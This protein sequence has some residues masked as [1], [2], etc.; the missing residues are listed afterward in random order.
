VERSLVARKTRGC[1]HLAPTASDGCNLTEFGQAGLSRFAMTRVHFRR[2]WTACASAIIAVSALSS[3][4]NT[5]A[6]AQCQFEWLIR[7]GPDFGFAINAPNLYDQIDV[8]RPFWIAFGALSAD[9]GADFDVSLYK[10]DPAWNPCPEPQCFCTLYANSILGSGRTDFVVGDFNHNALT[11][12]WVWTHCFGGSCTVTPAGQVAWRSGDLIS[13]NA[14]PRTVDITAGSGDGSQVLSIFDVYLSAGTTYYFSFHTTGDRQSKLLLFANVAAGTYWAGRASAQFETDQCMTSYAAPVTGY[15]GVVVVNDRLT[16]NPASFRLAVTTSV[17]CDCPTVLADDVSQVLPPSPG[18]ARDIVIQG[19]PMW[20][21]V[22]ARSSADWDL[23]VGNTPSS[24]PDLG[25]PSD[26]LA[27]SNL[28]APK[29]DVLA[30]D[31][32]WKGMDPPSHDTVSVR[33]SLFSGSAPATVQMDGTTGA[34]D[35]IPDNGA[36]QSGTLYAD[37]VLRVW[38]VLLSQDTTYTFSLQTCCA[39]QRLL[40][41]GNSNH[42]VQWVGRP[43]AILE[44]SSTATFKPLFTGYYG[45]VVLKEDGNVGGFSLGFGHCGSTTPLVTRTPFLWNRAV[46]STFDQPAGQWA[47]VGVLGNQTDWDIRQ[48][49]QASGSSWPDCFGSPGALSAGSSSMDFIVGDFHHNPPGPQYARSYQFTSGAD[50]FS[51]TEWDSGSGELVVNDTALT[52]TMDETNV[53]HLWCYQVHLVSGLPY[54]F[55]FSRVGAADTHL[56]LFMNPT[57]GGYWAPRSAAVFSTTTSQP[58]IAPQTGWYG[59]V[60]TLDNWDTGRFSLRVSSP[61]LDVAGAPRPVRDALTALTPNPARGPLHVAFDLAAAAEPAFEVLD[62][63]GRVRDTW[64][65]QA[66]EPGHW[67]ITMPAADDRGK[68]LEPGIYFVRM[69]LGPRT[70]ATRKLVIAP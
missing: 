22:G 42:A 56:H 66:F 34:T 23:S 25:C 27:W 41:F 29:T 13:V 55:E 67:D 70:V 8:S 19:L 32:N 14:G 39:D 6:R 52:V 65:A 37:D 7:L 57:T 48:Y 16:S 21:A 40:L 62:A 60:V 24:T 59:V 38:D 47:G 4:V 53:H 36:H 51:T 11:S 18:D 5:P 68:A 54:T 3:I 15:Y 31:Y 46:Y 30:G 26:L 9:P 2:T 63:Q 10:K 17:P 50:D 64:S 49:D 33:V 44:T 58:Y 28:L 43:D 45:A 69:R 12:F 61:L 1:D 35:I 20:T